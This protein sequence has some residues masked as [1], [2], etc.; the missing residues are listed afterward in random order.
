M[1]PQ[2]GKIEILEK[3][4]SPTAQNHY[5]VLEDTCSDKVTKVGAIV[6]CT[7]KVSKQTKAGVKFDSE[8]P[9]ESYILLET[10]ASVL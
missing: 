7:K 9:L 8:W 3:R 1:R 10:A 5:A 2:R 6:S 4:L